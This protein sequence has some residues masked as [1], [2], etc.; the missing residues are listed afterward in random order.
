MCAL[1]S[2]IC[3]VDIFVQD[4]V[5]SAVTLLIGFLYCLRTLNKLNFGTANVSRMRAQSKP[6]AAK[7]EE[8]SGSNSPGTASQFSN[9]GHCEPTAKRRAKKSESKKLSAKRYNRCIALA[10]CAIAIASTFSCSRKLHGAATAQPG[11]GPE[12]SSGRV[13]D[14]AQFSRLARPLQHQWTLINWGDANSQ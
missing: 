4:F 11:A 3:W 10:A 13:A 12:L 1:L 5:S 2:Q 6:T 14:N 7:F 9:F 8:S